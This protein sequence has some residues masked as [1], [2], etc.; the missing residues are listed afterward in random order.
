MVS[1][2]SQQSLADCK[3]SDIKQQNY[4][5]EPRYAY[6]VDCHIDYGRLRKAEPLYKKQTKELK[7][8]IEMKDLALK[9]SNERTETWKKTTYKL[10][11]KMLKLEENHDRMKWVYFGLGILTT[12][13]AVWAAGQIK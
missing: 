6:P 10:E 3:P 12:G 11:D 1:L 8:S 9:Y 4:Y 2:V 7:K 5:G 13:A